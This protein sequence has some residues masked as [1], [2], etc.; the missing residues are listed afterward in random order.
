MRVKIFSMMLMSVILFSADGFPKGSENRV[1]VSQAAYA[2]LLN[3][4]LSS[5]DG[6]CALS[7]SRSENLQK[8]AHK[9]CQMGNFIR[10]NRKHLL[11]LMRQRNL[12]PRDYKVRRFVHQVY[13]DFSRTDNSF[14]P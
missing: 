11:E 4:L 9:A 12:K 13:R 5:C 2:E 14:L 8:C 3:A 1:P 10:T 6:K 7:R